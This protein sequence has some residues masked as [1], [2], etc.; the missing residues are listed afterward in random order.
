[1]TSGGF[2]NTG[3][4]LYYIICGGECACVWGCVALPVFTCLCAIKFRGYRLYVWPI[5]HHAP[6][7]D[8]PKCG[9]LS[10]RSDVILMSAMPQYA[11]HLFFLCTWW[12]VLFLIPHLCSILSPT[13][14]P[15]F[16]LSSLHSSSS[17]FYFIASLLSVSLTPPHPTLLPLCPVFP[18]SG[19]PMTIRG[20]AVKTPSWPVS[21]VRPF[22]LVCLLLTEMLHVTLEG[23]DRVCVY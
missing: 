4:M 18:P 7:H 11:G 20:T 16:L 21:T 13:L 22:A 5:Q 1:M 15:P 8:P 17:P 19:V 6:H 10:H 2:S 23:L 3:A 9:C 12:I 14:S